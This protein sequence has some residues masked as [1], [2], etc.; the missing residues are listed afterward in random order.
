MMIFVSFVWEKPELKYRK[1]EIEFTC[2]LIFVFWFWFMF[3]LYF[4]CCVFGKNSLKN[5]VWCNNVRTEPWWDFSY[6]VLCESFIF[7]FFWNDWFKLHTINEWVRCRNYHENLSTYIS[8]MVYHCIQLKTFTCVIRMSFM[9]IVQVII[10]TVPFFSHYHHHH[11]ITTWLIIILP[12]QLYIWYSYHHK[13][14]M[15]LIWALF[16]IPITGIWKL[17]IFRE[18]ID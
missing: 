5:V 12:P 16:Y 6:W 4:I 11:R 17:L 2:F 14:L 1:I 18:I 7:F 13:S 15:L 8:L 3:R 10:T 9:C